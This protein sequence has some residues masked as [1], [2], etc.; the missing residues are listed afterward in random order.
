M[1]NSI[2]SL[3]LLLLL[4]CNNNPKSS[5]DEKIASRLMTTMQKFLYEQV[6]N[7]STK[8]K[9]HVNKVYYF[10]TKQIYLCE[11]NVRVVSQKLD[12]TGVMTAD[13]SRDFLTV[14]RKS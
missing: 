10:E 1:R 12:T 14:K 4:S 6:S 3:L 8:V 5:F 7:D 9:Y 11:F 2:F 13:I